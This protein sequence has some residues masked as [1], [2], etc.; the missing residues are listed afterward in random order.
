MAVCHSKCWSKVFL[1]VNIA[2]LADYLD[3]KVKSLFGLC[4]RIIASTDHF[5]P[6][7]RTND[8]HM[9]A[10]NSGYSQPPYTECKEPCT[11]ML[12]T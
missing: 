2:L 1:L 12:L 10:K 5:L 3:K 9:N 11:I 7:V 4:F 8:K 6:P